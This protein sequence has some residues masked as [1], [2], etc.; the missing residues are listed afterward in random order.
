MSGAARA[1]GK[2]IYAAEVF[3]PKGS[4]TQAR[5]NLLRE[6]F[7]G[8]ALGVSA[9]IV[10]KMYHW[11]EKKRIAE[12]YS[13]LAKKEQED[14]AAYAAELRNKFKLLEEELLA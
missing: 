8:T 13:A 14:E 6:I 9:G 7:V 1:A 5:F 12:Y 10:W 4:L 11:G 2:A 3:V